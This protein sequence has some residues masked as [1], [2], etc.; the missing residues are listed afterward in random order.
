[1]V[2]WS[3]WGI[4][5]VLI[6]AP[7]CGIVAGAALLDTMGQQGWTGLAVGLGLLAAAAVNG[8]AGQRLNGGSGRLLTD[9]ATSQTVVPRRRHSLFLI[10]M[11]WWPVRLAIPG[12]LTVLSTAAFPPNPSGNTVRPWSGA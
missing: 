11:Q 3:G 4:L 8:W 6:T 1:M 10:P 9:Q 5:A 7:A 12:A 2:I